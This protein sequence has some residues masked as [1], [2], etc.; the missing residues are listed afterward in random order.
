MIIRLRRLIAPIWGGVLRSKRFFLALFVASLAACGGTPDSTH[1][2]SPDSPAV[3]RTLALSVGP[4][5]GAPP[6]SIVIDGTL[7]VPASSISDAGPTSSLPVS[8][9]TVDE[10]AQTLRASIAE[11]DQNGNVTT[12]EAAEPAYDLA[13][14]IRSG[15]IPPTGSREGSNGSVAPNALFESPDGGFSRARG[16]FWYFGN[17]GSSFPTVANNSTADNASNSP[18]NFV[19]YLTNNTGSCSGAMIAPYTLVSAAHCFMENGTWATTNTYYTGALGSL[20]GGVP[21]SYSHKYNG[22]G[23]TYVTS[24]WAS[25]KCSTNEGGLA[26]TCPNNDYAITNFSCNGSDPLGNGWFGWAYGVTTFP[27]LRMD[28]YPGWYQFGTLSG[29][30]NNAPLPVLS[31]A[32]GGGYPPCGT[33]QNPNYYWPFLCGANLASVSVYNGSEIM[34]SSGG[35]SAPGDSGG[36]WWGGT[37]T[38]VYGTT[39]GSFYY[40]LAGCSNGGTCYVNVARWFDSTWF[41]FA[42]KYGGL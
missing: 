22:C 9:Q 12:Y 13:T 23:T 32:F 21:S 17:N 6:G 19:V 27:T 37:G 25:N 15:A 18:Y 42:Q 40:G 11:Q 7:F 38:Y 24:A 30:P 35:A 3:E 36:P 26:T 4:D 16:T 34:Q 31:A 41:A 8:Q 29:D 1:E 10:L 33:S 39:I 20:G 2:A 14:A 28:G 5:S